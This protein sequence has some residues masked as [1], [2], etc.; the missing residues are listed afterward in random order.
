MRKKKE[1]QAIEQANKKILLFHS[2][3]G[4]NLR[5]HFKLQK[6]DTKEN[7]LLDSLYRNSR[8]GKISLWG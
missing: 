4:M 8:T 3:T 7:I 5:H 1:P 2:I 6:P